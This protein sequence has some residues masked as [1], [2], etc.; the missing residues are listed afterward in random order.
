MYSVSQIAFAFFCGLFAKNRTKYG[1]ALLV[2]L[3]IA[4]MHNPALA[5]DGTQLIGIGPIQKG[6]GGAGVASARD[7][8]WAIL[9]PASIIALGKRV[10]GSLEVFAPDRFMDS[11]GPSGLANSAAGRSEDDSVFYIPTIGMICDCEIGTFGMGIYGINGM[12]VDYNSSRTLPGAAGGFDRRTEY[13]VAKAAFSYAYPVSDSFTLGGALNLDYAR[14][15]TD[16]LNAAFAQTAGQ[17]R[18]DDAFGM[19]F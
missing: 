19:G 7:A 8:T 3:S 12:G 5:T 9:N 17:N 1:L 13:A 2:A 14:L 6:T 16:S 15:R 10:D 18:W 11:E 4:V